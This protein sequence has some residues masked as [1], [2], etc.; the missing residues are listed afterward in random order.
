MPLGKFLSRTKKYFSHVVYV[1][2]L[3]G[4]VLGGG[5]QVSF[6]ANDYGD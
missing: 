5:Y 3:G 4:A 1:V 2:F 6:V